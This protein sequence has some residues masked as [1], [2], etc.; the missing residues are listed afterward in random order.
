MIIVGE[1]DLRERSPDGQLL[2]EIYT[3]CSPY[4]SAMNKI[5]EEKT[6]DANFHFHNISSRSIQVSSW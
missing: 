6:P 5:L 3:D 2:H 4:Q 1:N